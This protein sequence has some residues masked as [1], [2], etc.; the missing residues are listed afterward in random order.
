LLGI[1]GN[2]LA[3]FWCFSFQVYTTMQ[4]LKQGRE[5]WREQLATD[6]QALVA[7]IHVSAVSLFRR[8]FLSSAL[9]AVVCATLFF[10]FF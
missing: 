7:I 2:I 1:V 3:P 5:E 4:L 8:W 10:F 6:D 9:R